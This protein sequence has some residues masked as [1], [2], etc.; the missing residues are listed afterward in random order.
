MQR[1]RLVGASEQ[2]PT[3]LAQSLG[4]EREGHVLP[5]PANKMP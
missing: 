5:P 2:R 4:V 3:R 1:N